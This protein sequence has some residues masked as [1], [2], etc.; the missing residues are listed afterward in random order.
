VRALHPQGREAEGEGRA[1]TLHEG[2]FVNGWF[3]RPGDPRQHLVFG[4]VSKIIPGSAL[5]P[6]PTAA[7]RDDA[8]TACG[9]PILEILDAPERRAEVRAVPPGRRGRRA[10]RPS[11]DRAAAR[12][13]PGVNERVASIAASAT[14]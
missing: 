5:D 8:A 13:G 9:L 10:E 14:T 7:L 2:D 12:G 4:V 11:L 1:V 6:G 3:V